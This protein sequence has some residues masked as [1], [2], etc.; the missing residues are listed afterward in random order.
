MCSSDLSVA[1]YAV[2]IGQRLGLTGERI[3]RLRRA[4]FLHDIGKIG[5]RS[6]VLVKPARLT[7]AEFEEIK[8]HPGLGARILA[9]ANLDEEAGWVIAHHER[10]DGAGYP[11]RLRGDEI[12]LEARILFVADSFEAMTSDRPYRDGRETPEALD[13][14]RRCSSTQFDPD[15]VDALIALVESG[16]LA[17]LA[18]R[19]EHGPALKPPSVA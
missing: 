16:D 10:I 18:V 6:E 12:P 2:A 14:L 17:V 7:D 11:N 3:L 8:A 13:E 9:Q 4:A 15:V 5:V 19:G 1:S